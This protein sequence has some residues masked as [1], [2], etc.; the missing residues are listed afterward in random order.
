MS[1]KEVI[2]AVVFFAIMIICVVI[3]G[4]IDYEFIQAGLI[5]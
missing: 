4:H 5:P 1:R 2:Q 3:G